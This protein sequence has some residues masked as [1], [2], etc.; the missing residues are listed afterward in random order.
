MSSFYPNKKESSNKNLGF[1]VT[2]DS[3]DFEPKRFGLKYNPPCIS[4]YIREMLHFVIIF[5]PE[6]MEYLVPSTGKLYHHK[7]KLHQLTN[8]SD[9]N[10]L[11]KYL[12]KKHHNYIAND[13]ISDDQILSDRT[14]YLTTP[15]PPYY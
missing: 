2:I 13:K 15:S 5:K 14:L 1:Q 8:T 4:I 7:I 6:V 11:L 3:N 10:D 12:K 9:L